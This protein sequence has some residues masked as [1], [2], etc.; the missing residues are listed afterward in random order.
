MKKMFKITFLVIFIAL[1]PTNLVYADEEQNL[2]EQLN[3]LGIAE[4]YTD[5]IAQYINDIDITDEEYNSIIEKGESVLTVVDGK[6]SITDFKISELYN[7]YDNITSILKKLNLSMKIDFKNR[8]FAVVDKGT[9]NVLYKGHPQD[10]EKYYTNYENLLENGKDALNLEV[11]IKDLINSD[12]NN[13]DSIM[14]NADDEEYD[15]NSDKTTETKPKLQVKET[16]VR[17]DNGEVKTIEE[18]PSTEEVANNE[19]DTSNEIVKTSENEKSN[20]ENVANVT[21]NAVNDKYDTKVA[22][23]GEIDDKV[24]YY[25]LGGALLVLI[26]TTCGKK[27]L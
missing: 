4:E 15:F 3:E 13:N 19:D 1:M 18:K 11:Y 21:E 5:N 16:E 7:V 24:I 26:V 17:E 25:I 12:K 22:M 10:I 6:D 14:V 27:L 20:I 8:Q 2:E 23:N 9:N